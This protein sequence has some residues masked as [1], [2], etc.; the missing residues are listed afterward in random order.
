MYVTLVHVHVKSENVDDF[1]E[2]SRVNH[3]ASVQEP[4]NRRFDFLRSADDPCKFVFYEA[5]EDE[6]GARAHKDTEHYKVWRETVADWMAEPRQGIK[7][8]GLAPE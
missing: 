5:Y 1:V 7:Y 6:A 3:E 4:A 8:A 2:A